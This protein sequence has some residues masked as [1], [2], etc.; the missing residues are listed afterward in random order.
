M[1]N[2]KNPIE[3]PPPGTP[4]PPSEIPVYP[5]QK[6]PNPNDNPLA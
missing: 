5:P 1:T 4:E 6:T 3:P 2:T